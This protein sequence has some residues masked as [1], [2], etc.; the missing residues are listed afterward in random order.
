MAQGLKSSPSR[1]GDEGWR[2]GPPSQNQAA[3]RVTCPGKPC[4]VEGGAVR[5]SGEVF[6]AE[7][8]VCANAVEVELGGGEESRGDGDQR[9]NGE[10][11]RESGPEVVRHTLVREFLKT[12]SGVCQLV[13]LLELCAAFCVSAFCACSGGAAEDD[14]QRITWATAEAVDEVAV[15]VGGEVVVEDPEDKEGGGESAEECE[16][17]QEG[18]GGYRVGC[19][20]V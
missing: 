8:L 18:E 10:E 20:S 4:R 11:A 1:A 7:G 2:S 12:V 6:G 5:E 14:Q 16:G 15:S 13:Q 17:V 3:G 19:S 9:G